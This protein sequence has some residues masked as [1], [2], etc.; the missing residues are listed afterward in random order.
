MWRNE[1]EEALNCMDRGMVSPFSPDG[2]KRWVECCA[3]CFN[4]AH[5]V[6]LRGGR[7]AKAC[8]RCL[9]LLDGQPGMMR[10][11]GLGWEEMEEK[12]MLNK[13]PMKNRIKRF[14]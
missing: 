5:I 12:G 2:V 3:R 4:V 7:R 9:V 11:D 6:I 10:E 14:L 1:L 8:P 13:K